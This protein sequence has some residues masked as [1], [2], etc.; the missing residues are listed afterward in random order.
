MH[1]VA[2]FAQLIRTFADR[3][4]IVIYGIASMVN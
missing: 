1:K 2:L 3:K 4:E